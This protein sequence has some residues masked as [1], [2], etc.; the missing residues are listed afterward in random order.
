V[1][2]LDR[3][4]PERLF[5]F[6]RAA[7]V[8]DWGQSFA[9]QRPVAR[10]IAEALPHTAELALAA[11]LVALAVGIPLGAAAARGAGSGFD[12]GARAL[13]L[14][15]WSV[16]SFWLGLALMRGL[17]IELP[18]FPAGGA[19]APGGGAGGRSWFDGSIAHLV[20]PAL[21]LGL[22]AA[23][24]TARFVRAALLD[25]LSEPFV[26]AAR[27]RGLS[28]RAVFV[29]HA[30]RAACAPLVQIA[31]LSAAGLLSGAVAIEVVFSRPGLGRVACD[32]LAARDYPV[33]LASTAVAT[34]A[35]VLVSLI[36]DLGHAALDP[37][38]AAAEGD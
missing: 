16:P 20:L 15:V 12:R 29:G 31:A 18:L 35:V 2:G 7:L 34:T 25:L 28:E 11:L 26:F 8:G 27:A 3:P 1:L 17:A 4:A 14:V 36:G 19:D 9:Q 6:A 22:P 13:S 30:L 24:G 38:V 10:L 32:A 21:A 23:A 33:L 37:R 5:R